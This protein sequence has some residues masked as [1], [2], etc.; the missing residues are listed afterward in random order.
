MLYFHNNNNRNRILLNL[1]TRLLGTL[2][3]KDWNSALIFSTIYFEKKKKVALVCIHFFF[4]NVQ[5]F[6]FLVRVKKPQLSSFPG[7]HIFFLRSNVMFSHTPS[8]FFG[9]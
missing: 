9:H 5:M 3:I 7:K 1:G 2:L 8:L 4:L 6:F